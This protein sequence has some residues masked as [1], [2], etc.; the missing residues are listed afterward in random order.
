MLQNLS[1]AA[2]VIGA[3]RANTHNLIKKFIESK[4]SD[5]ITPSWTVWS[6]SV[7]LTIIEFCVLT[8]KTNINSIYPD[9][10]T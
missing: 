7:L 5:Q 10:L 6:G 1:S 4:K 8:T 9:Q 2:V 3:L